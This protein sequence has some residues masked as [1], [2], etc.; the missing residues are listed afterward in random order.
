M[1]NEDNLLA[2]LSGFSVESVVLS[3]LSVDQQIELFEGADAVITM[4]GAGLAN[5]IF[6]RKDLFLILITPPNWFGESAL[7]IIK[8]FGL[9]FS[10]I[11][12]SDYP[13][14][15]DPFAQHIHLTDQ[16][17]QAIAQ[18]L[19]SLKNSGRASS[20]EGPAGIPSLE[21]AR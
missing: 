10:N 3:E 21:S 11:I 7:D 15:S 18:S 20:K 16:E 2:H 19:A 6:A 17:I 14:K 1:L 8:P 13:V 9:K 5:L 4:T 12:L